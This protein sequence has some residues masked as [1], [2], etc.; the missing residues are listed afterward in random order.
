MEKKAMP[1]WLAEMFRGEEL[2]GHALATRV[3]CFALLAVSATVFYLSEPPDTYIY[4]AILG[5]L[6]LAAILGYIA[7]RRGAPAWTRYGFVALDFIILTV[8]AVVVIPALNSPWPPQMALRTGVAVYFFLLVTLVA[9]SYSWRLMV[10]AGV[11]AA[12]AWSAGTIWLATRPGVTTPFDHLPGMTAAEDLVQ[13]LDPQFVDTDILIH[14]VVVLILVASA[15]ASVV[16][17]SGR[18]IVGQV[19][20]ARER[21]NLARYFSPNVVEALAGSDRPLGTTQRQDVAVLFADM[22]GFTAMSEVMEPEQV[23]DLLRDFHG[24]ME[25]QVFRHNGTLEKFIGGA[26]LATFGAPAKGERDALDALDCMRA[27]IASLEHWNGERADQGLDPIKMGIGVHYG[28]AVFGD[29]GSERNMAF[30]VIGD[31]VN[32][33]SRLQTLTRDLKCAAVVSDSA[34]TAARAEAPDTEN[35]AIARLRK[36]TRQ[37]LRGRQEPVEIWTFDNVHDFVQGS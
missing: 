37:H 5:L 30:A 34:V 23:M 28:P 33:A 29:I 27:M 10:W 3:R 31:T 26:M 35:A 24:R 16:H 19:A 7:D 20:A 11:A 18:L 21:A 8:T 14:Q 36:S 13:H 15:L 32:T 9:F 6:A 12:V 4:L 17:R 22:V 2:A 25:D 1:L